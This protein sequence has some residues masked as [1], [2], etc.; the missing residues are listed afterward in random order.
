VFFNPFLPEMI[1]HSTFDF[2]PFA[3]ERFKVFYFELEEAEKLSRLHWMSKMKE[4]W[5]FF[6]TFLN[7]DEEQ[8]L[9]VFRCET[10]S[11]WNRL[12]AEIFNSIPV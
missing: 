11:D 10:G 2:P 3:L 4:F 7:V 5:K 12:M 6:G 1:R 9:R 8:R